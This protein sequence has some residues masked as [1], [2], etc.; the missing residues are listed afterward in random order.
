MNINLCTHSGTFST[1]HSRQQWRFCSTLNYIISSNELSSMHTGRETSHYQA[2]SGSGFSLGSL[3][4]ISEAAAAGGSLW[5]QSGVLTNEA[6]WHFLT[7]NN[8]SIFLSPDC[9]HPPILHQFPQ[10][11]STLSHFSW[12][13]SKGY[14]QR[15][16]FFSMLGERKEIKKS[17][18]YCSHENC[19]LY[20]LSISQ[21]ITESDTVYK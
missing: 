10:S 18:R 8:F 9:P 6:Q 4:L 12:Q 13:K 1:C 19:G 11:L 2:A 20:Q 21:Y 7:S 16:T 15:R 5:F 3:V 14:R 17:E